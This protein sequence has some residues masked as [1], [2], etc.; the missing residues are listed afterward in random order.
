MSVY[1][2]M[3]FCLWLSKNIVNYNVV[4][5]CNEHLSGYVTVRAHLTSLLSQPGGGQ[6]GGAQAEVWEALQ[7]GDRNPPEGCRQL[8]DRPWQG[9]GYN[10][11]PTRAFQSQVRHLKYRFH[12]VYV[13]I[14]EMSSSKLVFIPSVQSITAAHSLLTFPCCSSQGGTSEDTRRH[15]LLLFLFPLLHI[16]SLLSSVCQMLIFLR[17]P[18]SARWL[19]AVAPAAHMHAWAEQKSWP[20][21]SPLLMF[22]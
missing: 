20:V 17:G 11:P 10:P 14:W 6:R 9:R 21:M 16:F 4:R 5:G 12:I 15:C 18:L 19:I 2:M 3:G 8:H 22:Y 7:W 1:C 13:C